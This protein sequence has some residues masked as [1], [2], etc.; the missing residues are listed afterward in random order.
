MVRDL[1]QVAN[2]D[3]YLDDTIF[4]GGRI[5]CVLDI[6]FTNHTK[7]TN[8]VDRGSPEH[9]VV[10]VGE[11]LRRSYDDR[12]SRVYSQRVKVLQW[13]VRTGIGGHFKSITNLHI[14]NSDAVI[15]AIPYN[16]VFDLLPALHTLLDKDLRTRSKGFAA[17]RL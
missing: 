2:T 12:I 3:P 4:L 17:Q 6:A 5:Q 15:P 10:G 9:V 13:R 14:A 16:L 11:G 8:D 7:V 1:A